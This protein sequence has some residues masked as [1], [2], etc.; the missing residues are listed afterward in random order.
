M[1]SRCKEHPYTWLSL[2]F[3]SFL[4]TSGEVTR[5]VPSLADLL[6]SDNETEHWQANPQ[7]SALR[8][9]SQE[10]IT[11]IVPSLGGLLEEDDTETCATSYR[12]C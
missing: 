9:P 12:L 4:H 11:A 3:K 8:G 7:L 6:Q 10:N 1:Q 2:P 5:G